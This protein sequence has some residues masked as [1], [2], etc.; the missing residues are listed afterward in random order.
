MAHGTTANACWGLLTVAHDGTTVRRVRTFLVV[1]RSRAFARAASCVS[2]LRRHLG[3]LC[4]LVEC[5]RAL[6][7]ID[8]A[9]PVRSRMEST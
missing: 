5:G 1:P 2:G 3:Y 9:N 7:Q 4:K 8:V 6:P